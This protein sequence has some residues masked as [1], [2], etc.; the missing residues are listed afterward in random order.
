MAK[1]LTKYYFFLAGSPFQLFVKTLTSRTLTTEVNAEDTVL[2][3]KRQIQDN[4]GISPDSLRL[5]FAGMQLED[6]RTLLDYN[7]QK[8]STIHMILRLRGSGYPKFFLHVL[9]EDSCEVSVAADENTEVMEIKRKICEIRRV[10]LRRQRLLVNDQ[11]MRNQDTLGYY[12]IRQESCVCLQVQQ[13]ESVTT[14]SNQWQFPH[15]TLF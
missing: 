13:E 10:D 6:S 4:E 9:K 14:A 7:I 8:E 5:T 2:M 3:V 15:C 11:V 12:G 1:I